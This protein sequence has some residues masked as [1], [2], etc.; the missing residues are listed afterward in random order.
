MPKDDLEILG[1][2]GREHV[3]K[4]YSFENYQKKWKEIIDE[5]LEK[6]GTWDTRKKYKRWTL[7]EIK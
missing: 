3:M 6:Y 4:N 7:Q 2:K 5:V 1:A